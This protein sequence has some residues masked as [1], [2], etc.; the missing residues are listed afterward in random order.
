MCDGLDVGVGHV[1]EE[2]VVGGAGTEGFCGD[3]QV[4]FGEEGVVDGAGTE[5][6]CKDG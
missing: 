2:D 4:T 6:F 1:C 5:G 3:G